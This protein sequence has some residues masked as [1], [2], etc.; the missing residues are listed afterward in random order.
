MKKP[1]GYQ[2]IEPP[3]Y[4][5]LNWNMDTIVSCLEVI[6]SKLPE[7]FSGFPKS[8]KYELISYSNPFGNPYPVIRIYSDNSEDFKKIPDFLDLYDEMEVWLHKIGIDNIKR[9]S[10]K[11]VTIN[12]ET[13]KRIRDY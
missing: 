5:E 10:E 12:W 8:V 7:L 13:L 6:R 1:R 4:E 2:I 3:I 11:I 9:E